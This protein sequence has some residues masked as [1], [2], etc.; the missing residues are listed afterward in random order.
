MNQVPRGLVPGPRSHRL[1]GGTIRMGTQGS[2]TPGSEDHCLLGIGRRHLSG[3]GPMSL[4]Y[5]HYSPSRCGGH[6]QNV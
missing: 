5:F 6:E 4:D 3:V 2:V 1:V